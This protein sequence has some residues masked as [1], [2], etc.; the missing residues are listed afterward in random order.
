[1]KR[2]TVNSYYNEFRRLILEHLL[3]EQERKL[4]EF[5]LNESYF[6]ARRIRGK[7]RSSGKNTGFRTSE[8]KRKCVCNGCSELLSRRINADYSGKNFQEFDDSY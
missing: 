1:M 8:K 6:G 7:I 3:R 4:G 5:E 2:K